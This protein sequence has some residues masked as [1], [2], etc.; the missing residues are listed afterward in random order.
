MIGDGNKLVFNA[1]DG[2]NGSTTDQN[3]SEITPT[4]VMSP[5]VA[6]HTPNHWETRPSPV[7]SGSMTASKR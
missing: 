2:I 6:A 3:S 4:R 1:S 5:I 7:D